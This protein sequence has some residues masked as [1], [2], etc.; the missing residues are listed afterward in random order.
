MN[1]NKPS[2]LRSLGTA[3]AVVL[4]IVIFAYGV[5]VTNVNFETTQ[6]ENRIT[7]LKRVIR[8]LVRPDIVEYET[9]D[10]DTEIPFY[11]PCPEN[12]ELEAP[13]PDTTEPY[14]TADT[15]CG[16]PEDI[17]HIEGFNFTPYSKG[18]VN[19]ITASGVKKQLGNFETDGNG[20]FTLDVEI[21]LRQ[22]LWKPPQSFLRVQLSSFPSRPQIV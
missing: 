13:V 11:L 9:V 8:A 6:S 7:Q 3:L 10:T 16:S 17:I 19:F 22:L 1:K 20:T 2:L 12:V 18:P 5:N 14:L 21:P 4:G 15:Y